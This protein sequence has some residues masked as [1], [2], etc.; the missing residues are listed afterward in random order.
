MLTAPTT[1]GPDMCTQP[2]ESATG[3]HSIMQAR[4]RIGGLQL[5]P[6]SAV[7]A[8]RATQSKKTGRRAYYHQVKHGSP[9][10]A[11]EPR[12]DAEKIARSTGNCTQLIYSRPQKHVR[13]IPGIHFPIKTGQN[14]FGHTTR[15]PGICYVRPK[16]HTSR[17][18]RNP[19]N[20]Q[21]T[22]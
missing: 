4:P 19:T 16:F 6:Y 10:S 17:Q 12:T 11:N 3:A 1:V 14:R 18:K 5:V 9:R 7:R 15:I 20:S 8:P 21:L 22:A 13:P 2:A